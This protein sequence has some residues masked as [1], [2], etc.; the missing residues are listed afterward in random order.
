MYKQLVRQVLTQTMEIET[1]QTHTFVNVKGCATF[2]IM[3]VISDV[4]RCSWNSTLA[5]LTQD[6]KNLTPVVTV[7]AL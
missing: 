6:E 4:K 3:H 5:T 2:H 7:G 1:N